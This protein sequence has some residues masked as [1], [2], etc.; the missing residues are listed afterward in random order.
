VNSFCVSK[1]PRYDIKG[2]E[3]L[4]FYEKYYATDLGLRTITKT[5]LETDLSLVLETVLYNEFIARGYDVLVGKT[6]KGEVDFIVINEG[7]KC[8]V[9][10]CYLL[11]T[12]DTINREFGAYSPISDAS[13]K[14]VLSMDKFDLSREGIT[15]VNII[16]FLLHKKELIFS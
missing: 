13:P 12:Q 6:Y 7:K 2:K 16:D 9:Q 14:Y 3:I 10:V 15:H 4:Q 5:N 11:A 1:C 8:F